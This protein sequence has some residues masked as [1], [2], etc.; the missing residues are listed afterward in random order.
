[1]LL[2]HMLAVGA[3]LGLV[4]VEG[5]VERTHRAEPKVAAI[6]ADIH[7]RSDLYI[8]LPLLVLVLVSGIWLFELERF[9]GWYA[10]KVILGCLSIAINLFCILPV[11]RRHQAVMAEDWQRVTLLTATILRG[12]SWVLLFGIGT[13]LIAALGFSA[14]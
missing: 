11:V 9:S 8:E 6:V 4:M 13:L 14:S 12:G 3:W 1:M 5:V 10:A 7:Y 2:L